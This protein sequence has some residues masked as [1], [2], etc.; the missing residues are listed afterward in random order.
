[1]VIYPEIVIFNQFPPS[2]LSQIQICLSEDILKAL[3]ITIYLTS[4]TNEIMPPYPES[5]HDSG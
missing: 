1:M 2:S 5:V 3:V 4:M